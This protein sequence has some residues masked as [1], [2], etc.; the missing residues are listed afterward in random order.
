MPRAVVPALPAPRGQ[1]IARRAITGTDIV[2]VAPGLP[3][4]WQAAARLGNDRQQQERL[5]AGSGVQ[6]HVAAEH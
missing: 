4:R 1:G 6:G 3:G 5:V 2:Q